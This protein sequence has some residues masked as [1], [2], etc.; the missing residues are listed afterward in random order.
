MHRIWVENLSYEELST[1]A[2]M[3][4]VDGSELETL[5]SLTI[6]VDNQMIYC[7]YSFGD[8]RL[9]KNKNREQERFLLGLYNKAN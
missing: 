2:G 6:E 9:K 4:E 5:E 3:F 1:L 8:F 7:N